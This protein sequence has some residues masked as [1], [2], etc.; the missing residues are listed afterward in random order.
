LAQEFSIVLW[1]KNGCSYCHEVK[2]YLTENRLE[3]KMVDV[4]N[5]DELRDILDVKYGVRH[6][7]VVEIGKGNQYVAVTEVGIEHLHK[8]LSEV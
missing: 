5:H 2:E 8:A 6:V 7:P 1:A 3:Y 4:T